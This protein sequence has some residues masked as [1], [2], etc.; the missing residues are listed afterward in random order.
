MRITDCRE[1]ANTPQTDAVTGQSNIHMP[2][3]QG[4]IRVTGRQQSM[5]TVVW[6][7]GCDEERSCVRVAASLTAKRRTDD[8][9]RDSQETDDDEGEGSSTAVSA[10]TTSTTTGSS[11]NPLNEWPSLLTRTFILNF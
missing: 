9:S 5:L 2:I 3:R 10:S 4:M 11:F 7:V 1:T 6:K 8:A